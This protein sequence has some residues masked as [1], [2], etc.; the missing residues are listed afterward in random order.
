MYGL[1]ICKLFVNRK[2]VLLTNFLFPH[3]LESWTS[4]NFPLNLL[5]TLFIIILDLCMSFIRLVASIII[6]VSSISFL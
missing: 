4:D 5:F 6:A 2:L 1:V 3:N